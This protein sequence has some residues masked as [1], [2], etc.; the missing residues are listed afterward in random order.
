MRCRV[1]YCCHPWGS[2]PVSGWARPRPPVP[3]MGVSGSGRDAGKRAPGRTRSGG[4]R[5]GS[6]PLCFSR[7]GPD[8]GEGSGSRLK[9]PLGGRRGKWGFSV[10]FETRHPLEDPR[11]LL[12]PLG[13]QAGRWTPSQGPL[14]P[15][16]GGG[17]D[18]G[19][20]T[21]R[22]NYRAGLRRDEDP[23]PRGPVVT[24]SRTTSETRYNVVP[25]D[26]PPFPRHR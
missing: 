26:T 16:E 7:G 25:P 20:T 1:C 17:G 24:P 11:G 19:P 10:R 22:G 2:R 3:D 23:D 14:F 21:T 13:S 8:R 18:R 4:W 15:W 9:Q 5:S 12:G 6:L